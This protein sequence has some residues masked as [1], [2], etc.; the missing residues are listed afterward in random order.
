MR[1]VSDFLSG[2]AGSTYRP[3]FTTLKCL[4]PVTCSSCDAI[5]WNMAM[6][7]SP[8]DIVSVGRQLIMESIK[9]TVG[10]NEIFHIL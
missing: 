9:L 6:Y 10:R 3:I 5:L 8:V 4:L 1:S 7:L 2:T